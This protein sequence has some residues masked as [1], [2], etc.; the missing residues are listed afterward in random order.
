M[1]KVAL[2]NYVPSKF[3]QMASFDEVC[4]HYTILEFK[5]GRTK[6]QEWASKVVGKALSGKDRKDVVFVCTP[7]H[8]HT[9][10]NKRYASFS[11]N[12]CDICG[13]QDGFPHVFVSEDSKP[14]HFKKRNSECSALDNIIVDAPFF[15]NKKVILFDDIIT[16][17]KTIDKMR[18]I[19]ESCGAKVIGS[20]FLAKTI[21]PK[22]R[23]R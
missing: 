2:Y 14:I 12:V 18:D 17:G 22:I 11:K 5:D 21:H 20:V 16:T 4:M 8:C 10:N 3:L 7:A 13:C 1:I 9:M 19:M 23:G 15:K 6:A